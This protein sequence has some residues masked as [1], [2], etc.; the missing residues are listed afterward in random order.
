M[1]V[2]GPTVARRQVGRRLKAYREAAQVT[3]DEVEAA[4]LAS[5]T[6]LWRIERGQVR[7]T[8]PDIWALCRFYGV[9]DDEAK[10]LAALAQDTEEPGMWYEHR[11]VV[12]EWFRLYVGLEN[13]ATHIQSFED[14][15]VPGELQTPD[16]ARSLWLGAWPHLTEADIAPHIALRLKRQR[17]LST[18]IPPPRLAVVLGENVLRRQVGGST[19]MAAQRGHLRD[20]AK[21]D[22]VDLRVLPFSAGAHPAVT[23]AFRILRFTGSHDPDVVYIE[24]EL[25]AHY[26]EKPEH[27]EHY[28]QMFVILTERA[29]PLESF[30][31][32]TF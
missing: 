22:T 17:A 8:V 32:G 18:R 16:Y 25:E 4:Q 10:A 1:A 14:S 24:S 27:V 23:G 26:L 31:A 13:A 21:Q 9:G 6:K 11:H 28:R 3:A 12:P 7:V 5:R 15:V 30:M 20:L 29:E 2:S 19:V